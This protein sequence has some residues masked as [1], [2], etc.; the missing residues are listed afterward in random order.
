MSTKEEIAEIQFKQVLAKQKELLFIAE[1][2]D[3]FIEELWRKR[4]ET[5][6]EYLDSEYRYGVYDLWRGNSMDFDFRDT[7]NSDTIYAKVQQRV[8]IKKQ[9]KIRIM[10]E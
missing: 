2:V 5:V 9:K 8:G 10:K 7:G 4:M 1:N 6:N 3:L